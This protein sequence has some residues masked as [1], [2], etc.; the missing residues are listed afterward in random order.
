MKIIYT[1]EVD[2]D[3]TELSARW[4]EPPTFALLS[5]R[6]GVSRSWVQE[7]LSALPEKFKTGHFVLLT[8]GSTGQPKLVIASRWRAQELAHRIH[9][10]QENE[11]VQE[12]ILTLPLSYCYAFV[13]QWLWAGV[14]Q[15]RFVVTPGF[16]QPDLLKKKLLAADNAML[17]L[18]SPQIPLFLRHFGSDIRFPG[19][20]R[21]N[22]AGGPFPQNNIN[23]HKK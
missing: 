22:F 8:S 19:V 15:R 11:P 10:L 5:P 21:V 13:N 3:I 18:V 9:P 4:L 1:G 23:Q 2:K 17:C 16:S 7:G 6:S 12:T 20:I 14:S